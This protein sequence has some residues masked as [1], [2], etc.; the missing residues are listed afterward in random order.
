MDDNRNEMKISLD[1]NP[2]T[3]KIFYP[4]ST[5]CKI[6]KSDNNIKV[7]LPTTYS[8]VILEI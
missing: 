2:E 8:A 5:G 3:V 6:S 1:Y 7:Y 4:S